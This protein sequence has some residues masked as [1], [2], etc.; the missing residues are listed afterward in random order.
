MIRQIWVKCPFSWKIKANLCKKCQEC[1]TCYSFFK[2]LNQIIFQILKSTNW[3]AIIILLGLHLPLH[4]VWFLLSLVMTTIQDGWQ[5]VQVED[6]PK[7][8]GVQFSF[9]VSIF[10]GRVMAAI[11]VTSG[12]GS[13]MTKNLTADQRWLSKV[14]PSELVF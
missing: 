5:H 14:S 6:S 13:K 10:N 12:N 4:G 7:L 1:D 3:H 2:L 9:W 8:S 11:F